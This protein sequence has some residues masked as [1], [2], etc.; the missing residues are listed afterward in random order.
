M[1]LLTWFRKSFFRFQNASKKQ[2]GSSKEPPRGNLEAPRSPNRAP[3]EPQGGGTNSGA[4]AMERARAVGKGRERVNPFPRI[5]KYRGLYLRKGSTR[6]EAK[7]L[8]G[9]AAKGCPRRGTVHSD[10][11]TAHRDDASYA[12]FLVN[13]SKL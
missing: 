8:G 5:G 13:I 3:R 2:L 9:L 1:N 6:S 10:P 4:P 12:R 11:R 7:G